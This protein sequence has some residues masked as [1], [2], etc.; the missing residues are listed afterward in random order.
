MLSFL[1]S[2]IEKTKAPRPDAP[3]SSD[4]SIVGPGVSCMTN[5]EVL[6]LINQL[7]ILIEQCCS[8]I[9]IDFA[10][11]FTVLAI[12]VE[13]F[14][15]TFTVL[16]DIKNTLTTEFNG[17]F[18]ALAACCNEIFVDFNG[19]FTTLTDIKNTVTLD[20]NGTFSVL[21]SITEDF[22]DTFTVLNDIKNTLT[23]EFNGTFTALEAC[24]DE[25]FVD[26]NRVF[27]TLS[28]LNETLTAEFNGT[29][30]ALEACCDEIFVDFNGVFTTLTD[31]EN[32]LTIDF[33]GTFTV[34]EILSASLCVATP[35]T[36]PTTITLPGHYCLANDIFSTLIITASGVTV[37]L[38]N[39]TISA[40]GL[41]G[42]S[43][44]N[45]QSTISI[46]NGRINASAIGVEVINTMT[47]MLSNLVIINCSD[48]GILVEP[49]CN[50]ITVKDTIINTVANVGINFMGET[51][52]AQCQRVT[53]INCNGPF[54]I[55]SNDA[56]S[57][58]LFEDCH[59]IDCISNL[60]S[61]T[62]FNLA[63]G[64]NNQLIGCSVKNIQ[65]NTGDI[66]AF[67]IGSDVTGLE[68]C[69]VQGLRAQGTAH[70][71]VIKDIGVTVQNCLAIDCAGNESFG[72]NL[73]VTAAV[74]ESCLA[75]T[76]SSVIPDSAFGFNVTGSGYGFTDCQAYQITGTGFSVLFGEFLSISIFFNQMLFNCRSNNNG[77]GFLYEPLFILV[78]NCTAFNNAMVGFDAAANTIGQYGCFASGNGT[79]YSATIPNVQPASQ[80]TLVFARGN[81]FI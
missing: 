55:G 50:S 81:N 12:L 59:I 56:I 2:K 71:Y 51:N 20:F 31:I 43:I 67:A 19:V 27:T 54:G 40:P 6:D 1:T 41:P 35:I 10:G 74:L 62:A 60:V 13:D 52:I 39:H 8:I 17:T 65:N 32:T 18:T 61:F 14:V 11:T 76:V 28:S 37:D 21:V 9:Q 72:F 80:N 15:G 49:F 75:Q 70:G 25:I 23:T 42:V 36:A 45:A 46:F 16:N 63:N 73:T 66:I 22:V 77:N 7:I 68:R 47:V 64:I 4:G 58:S 78:G 44:V 24:C 3:G 79:N 5:E 34:L 26:F 38:N 69:K 53:L 57:S 48:T 33:N 30:T 29:F